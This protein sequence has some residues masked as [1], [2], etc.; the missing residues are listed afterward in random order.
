MYYII[1]EI[2]NYA[3]KC[4]S[5]DIFFKFLKILFLDLYDSSIKKFPLTLNGQKIRVTR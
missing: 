3:T 2:E 1:D 4:I 5:I